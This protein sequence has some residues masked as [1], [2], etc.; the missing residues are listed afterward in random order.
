MPSLS[1]Q[2]QEVR[3]RAEVGLYSG[4]RVVEVRAGVMAIANL[5]LPPCSKYQ[6]ISAET[7]VIENSSGSNRKETLASL[8]RLSTALNI[9]EKYGC[10][11]TNP[12]RPK[13]WRTVK[14]NNPVFRAT[15]DAIQGGRAVLCLYGYSNQQPDGLSFPDDVTDPD[16]GRVAAVTL[17]VMSLRMEL[18]MLIKETHPHPEFY[19]R[20]LA[21]LR[22]KDVGLNT[23][24]VV[25]YSSAIS[26][27]SD[28]QSKSLA[29]PLHH[30]STRGSS[31]SHSLSSNHQGLRSIQVFSTSSNKHPGGAVLE[32]EYFHM[33]V[34][35]AG[36]SSILASL[37]QIGPGFAK[38]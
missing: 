13:Y 2:L 35:R 17:E 28:G 32:I 12:N 31:H 38:L 25:Y 3:S 26:C 1:E 5:P 9:L 30:H 18:E 8:Q 27:N 34:F 11:L 7:M 37:V 6:H 21:T 16:V 20:I 10:N 15:V 24:A 36:L 33:D 14:H 4:G 23:D 22:H 19:E 29:F